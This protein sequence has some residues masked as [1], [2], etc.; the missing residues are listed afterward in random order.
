MCFDIPSSPE[1]GTFLWL[2][3]CPVTGSR[4]GGFRRFP[5]L[6]FPFPF[7]GIALPCGLG[8]TSF[9]NGCRFLCV[10]EG[11]GPMPLEDSFGE[12]FEKLQTRGQ[13]S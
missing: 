9:P 2:S 13:G 10:G 5:G 6:S 7:A 4:I 8:V 12:E 1:G 3:G 11:R